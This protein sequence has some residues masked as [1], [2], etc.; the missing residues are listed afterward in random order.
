MRRGDGPHR[1]TM[2][3]MP[4]CPEPGRRVESL[5]V[6]PLQRLPGRPR[7]PFA[8]RR[9]PGRP[10]AWAPATPPLATAAWAACR[11]AAARPRRS[12]GPAGPAWAARGAAGLHDGVQA[13][14][15]AQHGGGDAMAGGLVARLDVGGDGVQRLLHRAV[16]LQDGFQQQ[17]GDT[18]GGRG[19]ACS[20]GG[21]WP[22]T[23]LLHMLDAPRHAACSAPTAAT[24]P[25]ERDTAGP[26]GSTRSSAC[27]RRWP[28]LC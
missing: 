1:V 6:Q 12:A 14:H 3:R 13:A 5:A 28:R 17:R 25:H 21:L 8:A 20:S 15:P 19:R 24:L 22:S 7:R 10:R 9:S 11:A 18:T 2:R 4:G 26:P 16:L 23:R 27:R